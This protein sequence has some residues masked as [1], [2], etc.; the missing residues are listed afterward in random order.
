MI[1]D[2]IA[3]QTVACDLGSGSPAPSMILIS[4][5]GRV[6]ST[7]GDYVLDELSARLIVDAFAAHGV[8]L[9]IDFEHQTLGGKYAPPSGKAPAA[10]WIKSLSVRPGEGLF[11]RVVWTAEAAAD[12]ARRVYRYLSPVLLVRRDDQRAV[13]LHSAALTNKPAIVRMT[14]LVNKDT[15][16]TGVLTMNLEELLTELRGIL[17]LGADA[18]ASAVAAR[19][20]ELADSAK[21]VANSNADL[22]QVVCRDD[23]ERAVHR[24]EAA[25]DKLQQ[26]ELRAFIDEG[27]KAG[28][29]T[30]FMRSRWEQMFLVNPDQARD[31][32]KSAPQ[33]APADGR[34]VTKHASSVPPHNGSQRQTVIA[35]ATHE[36]DGESLLQ[37]IVDKVAH[38]NGELRQEKLPLLTDAEVA[39]IA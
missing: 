18:D 22:S 15:S 20:R 26:L 4:P 17:G 12:I 23:Y 24:A 33:V 6:K 36:W 5:W 21:A 1:V 19:V 9:P 16:K 32:L 29:I 2:S 3:Y 13:E 25:E 35:K 39:M 38:V 8:D 30:P 31:W 7:S 11:A 14:A 34:V 28:K 27:S 37:D 10:G